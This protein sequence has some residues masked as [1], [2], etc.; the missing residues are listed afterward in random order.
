MSS[1]VGLY[2]L[3]Q[4]VQLDSET[5]PTWIKIRGVFLN[6]VTGAVAPWE[7][8]DEFGP[9]HGWVHFELPEKKDQANARAEWK[10]LKEEAK[11]PLRD[12]QVLALGS[13]TWINPVFH[14][15]NVNWKENCKVGNLVKEVKEDAKSIPYPVNNGLLRIR[16]DSV[17][18]RILKKIL[19]K[20]SS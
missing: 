19:K 13:A 12:R 1:I 3:V 11:H 2:V 20:L 5:E 6:E 4:E 7:R 18:D 14:N 16:Q 10:D 17:P 9:R 15:G 8:E